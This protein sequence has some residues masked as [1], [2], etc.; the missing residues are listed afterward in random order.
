MAIVAV[1]RKDEQALK[2]W[3]GYIG[4]DFDTIKQTATYATHYPSTNGEIKSY[5]NE[6]GTLIPYLGTD[7]DDPARFAMWDK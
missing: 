5:T 3:S 1:K 2:D 7:K 6:E 4:E